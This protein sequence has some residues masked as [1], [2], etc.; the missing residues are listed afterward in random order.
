M[1]YFL[2]RRFRMLAWLLKRFAICCVAL[3]DREISTQEKPANAQIS[4][5]S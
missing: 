3:R 5:V 2:C 1:G 4:G